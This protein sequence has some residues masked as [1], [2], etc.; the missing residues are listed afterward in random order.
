MSLHKALKEQA[1][2]EREE[3]AE[4]NFKNLLELQVKGESTWLDYKAWLNEREFF[5]KRQKD[6]D[7]TKGSST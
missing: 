3:L 5:N 4:K 7:N 1:A 2:K 6:E